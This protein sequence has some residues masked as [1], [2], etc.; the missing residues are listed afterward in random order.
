VSSVLD[1]AFTPLVVPRVGETPID[2]RGEADRARTRGYADGFAEGRR[3]A[4][5]Q[6][7]LQQAEHEVRTHELLEAFLHERGSALRALATAQ[8]SLEQ[9]VSDLSMLAVERIEELALD[10]ATSIIGTELSD[11]ARSA[12]HAVRRALAEMPADRWSRVSFSEQDA[13]VIHDEPSLAD[14]L[15]GVEVTASSVVDPGGAIVEIEHGA[16]DTRII[17]AISR[18]AAALSGDD[19]QSAEVIV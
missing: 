7:Q 11:P 16:V 19:E 3:I 1:S 5:E 15:R 2:I 4:L 10:L 14:S 6:A 13:R 9:R 17:Q 18:A 12:A 8:T